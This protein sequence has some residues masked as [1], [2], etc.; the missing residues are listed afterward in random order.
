M[1]ALSS[2][3]L[4]VSMGALPADPPTTLQ[5]RE[6]VQRS[7]PYI[8]EQGQWWITKKKCVSCHRG[9]NMV[10]S[11]ALAKRNG[12]E[13]SQKLDEWFDW[14]VDKS[15]SKNDKGKIVGLGN[16]EGVAQILLSLDPSNLKPHQIDTQ[17]KLAALLRNGQQAD[18]SW[19]PGG[20]LPSQKRPITETASV[21]TMWLTLTLLVASNS[22]EG[23]QAVERAMKYIKQ[24]TPGKSIEWYALRL[25]LSV[26]T[27]DAKLRAE[28]VKKLRSQQKPDGGWGWMVTDESDALGTGLALY[29]LLRAGLDSNDQAIKR[30]QQFLVSTQRDDGSW[31]VK[32]TKEKKKNNVEETAVYWGTTWAAV[33]LI[34]SLPKESE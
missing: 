14:A 3:V 15:L 29:A 23:S 19:K 10:W 18:G 28:F 22:P 6:T 30:A 26:Q 32:G 17:N 25:L 21:S 11:L 1:I 9:G 34:E 12:F 8:E 5:I 24:S 16:K 13:V 4:A 2:L 20:Q 31:P 33:S 7:I 27:K